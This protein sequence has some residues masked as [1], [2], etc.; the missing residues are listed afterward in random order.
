LREFAND[1]HFANVR[2]TGTIVAMDV[3]TTESGYL[4]SVG[5]Q[6]RSAFRAANVLLRPLGNTI[7]ILS[8]YCISPADL[9]IIYG[10]IRE[11][12]RAL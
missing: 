4:A 7:Y 12:V 1:A 6:L 3:R 8:P 9:E 5:Q 11:T 10:A 2:Q